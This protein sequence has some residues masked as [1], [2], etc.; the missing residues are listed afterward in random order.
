MGQEKCIT[1]AKALKGLMGQGVGWVTSIDA[2][3]PRVMTVEEKE[4]GAKIIKGQRK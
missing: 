4:P 3:S 2:R 1:R